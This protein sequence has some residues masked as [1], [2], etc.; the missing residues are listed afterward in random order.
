MTKRLK[1]QQSVPGRRY[2]RVYSHRAV[3]AQALASVWPHNTAGC[4]SRAHVIYEL[5]PSISPAS[6]FISVPSVISS[7]RCLRLTSSDEARRPISLPLYLMPFHMANERHPHPWR[8][9]SQAGM[10]AASRTTRRYA[11]SRRKYTQDAFNGVYVDGY[12]HCS[13]H[14]LVWP[15]TRAPLNISDRWKSV[16]SVHRNTYNTISPEVSV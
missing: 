12:D 7:H 13:K 6:F 10:Q 9:R 2:R 8:L 14:N 5:P 1:A 4:G 3:E 11:I 15:D 16:L